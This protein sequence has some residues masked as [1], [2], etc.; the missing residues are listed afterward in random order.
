[1]VWNSGVHIILQLLAFVWCQMA[2]VNNFW[3][4]LRSGT[5]SYIRGSKFSLSP[6]EHYCYTVLRVCLC[7]VSKHMQYMRQDSRNIT[8]R[9]TLFSY[10][11]PFFSLS[12]T[13]TTSKQYVHCFTAYSSQHSAVTLSGLRGVGRQFTLFYIMHGWALLILLGKLKAKP[14]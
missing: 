12:I 13:T 14:W 6:S 9:R 11:S 2:S 5:F 1:M 3:H 10:Q 7:A 8:M 4:N